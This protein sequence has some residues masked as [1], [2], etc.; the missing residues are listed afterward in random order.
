MKG[1]NTLKAKWLI[2]ETYYVGV[3]VAK[4]THVGE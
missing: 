1:N 4:D 3:G 2:G